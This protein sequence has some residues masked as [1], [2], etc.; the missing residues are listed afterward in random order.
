VTLFDYGNIPRILSSPC[1]IQ[2]RLD[3]T[4]AGSGQQADIAETDGMFGVPM[5]HVCVCVWHWPLQAA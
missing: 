3:F 1:L 2:K 5:L 4:K